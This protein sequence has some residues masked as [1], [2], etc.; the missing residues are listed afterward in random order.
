M[1]LLTLSQMTDFRLFQIERLCNCEVDNNRKHCGKRRN[2]LLQAISPF[3][4]VF[5]RLVLQTCKK[6]VLFGKGLKKPFET[7]VSKVAFSPFPTMFSALSE[8]GILILS[9]FNLES[10][11]ALNLVQTKKCCK[12]KS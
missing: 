11:N 7:F 4:T 3:P 10:A 5:S 1:S 2:C 12:V 6:Q 8:I 9:T